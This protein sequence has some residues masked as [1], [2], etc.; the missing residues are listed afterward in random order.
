MAACVIG[1]VS[2]A[3]GSGS[4]VGVVLGGLFLGV[5]YN[6]LTMINLSPFFQMGIQG[7]VILVAIV[8]NTVVDRRNQQKLAKRRSV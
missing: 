2:I 6:A 4:V 8:A 3:G 7:F 5:L 1:G